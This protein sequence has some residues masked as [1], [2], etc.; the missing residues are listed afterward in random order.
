MRVPTYNSAVAIRDLEPAIV[1]RKTFIVLVTAGTLLSAIGYIATRAL[2]D[3]GPNADPGAI[4]DANALQSDGGRAGSSVFR[5]N[6][7]AAIN[8]CATRDDVDCLEQVRREAFLSIDDSE[9]KRI[10]EDDL[11]MLRSICLVLADREARRA[12]QP[13]YVGGQPEDSS[14]EWAPAERMT[15]DTI[16]GAHEQLKVERRPDTRR[17]GNTTSFVLREGKTIGIT[18][19]WQANATDLTDPF[20]YGKGISVADINNDGFADL[21]IGMER[22]AYVYINR[23]NGTYGLQGSV[24]PDGDFNGFVVAL[25][26]FDNDGWVDL[27]MSGYGGRRVLVRN[28]GGVLSND[29]L[30]EMPGTIASLTMA[31]G[32]GDLDRDGDLDVVLGNWSHGTEKNF[33]TEHAVNELWENDGAEIRALPLFDDEPKGSTLSVLL[34]DINNDTNMDIA[35]GNDQQPPDVFYMGRGDLGFDRAPPGMF[36]LVSFNTMSYES[37]DFDNDLRMDLYSTDMA[38]TKA[39]KVDYCASIGIEPERTRFEAMIV[40]AQHVKDRNVGGCFELGADE[41][42]ACMTAITLGIAV[43][44]NLDDLCDRVSSDYPAK[45]DYCR[46]SSRKIPRDD[47]INFDDYPTQVVSNRLLMGGDGAFIDV[48]E[49]AGVDRSNWSWTARAVDLDNDRFQDIYVGTGF[50]FL[51]GPKDFFI[52][53]A[54]NVVFYNVN[55]RS[56]RSMAP[57]FGLDDIVNTTSFSLS[58]VDADGDMD[59]ITYGH[60]AGIRAYENQVAGN[61]ITFVL[62]DR[63]GNS[64]CIGC[65]ITIASASGKQV[66]EIKASGGF[67]SC[68]E[69]IA[70]FGMADD[71]ETWDIEIVWSTGQRT[72]LENRLP[73]NHRYLITRKR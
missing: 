32:F 49:S 52:K 44:E 24:T 21:A 53:Q 22:G 71:T 63:R 35:I 45:R 73:V 6:L 55:G 29:G 70:Q 27:F 66:R 40:A 61:S 57:G 58:D 9:C 13:E 34:S 16:E 10:G 19:S 72:V 18:R 7:V 67:M 11:P 46:R 33:R 42:S 15:Y 4:D 51:T 20:I 26:D 54:A 69:P 17:D 37:A 5:D 8:L 62:R 36:P 39:T 31:A 64:Q 2:S 56:F 48:S 23:G 14:D 65:R 60:L 3:S 43:K 28:E 59:I 41:L 47:A 1:N 12:R 50:G 25:V 38:D 30:T 68:D